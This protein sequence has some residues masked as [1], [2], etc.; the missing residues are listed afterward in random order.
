MK[1]DKPAGRLDIVTVLGGKPSEE[2]E[3][4][5]ASPMDMAC[6]AMFKAIKKDDYGT[7]KT[8]L[9]DYLTYRDEKKT[10]EGGE[11]ESTSDSEGDDY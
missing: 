10:S 4:D 11:G 6:K 3:D 5:D 2:S 9:D 8:A 7:F 1:D